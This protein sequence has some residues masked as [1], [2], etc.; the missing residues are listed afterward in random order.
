MF[1]E[2]K[3]ESVAGIKF[4]DADIFPGVVSV[5]APR[6][7]SQIEFDGDYATDP[8]YTFNDQE[9]VFRPSGL[10]VPPGEIVTLEFES[11]A[12]GKGL[13]ARIGI[14]RFDLEAGGWLTFKRFPRISNSFAVNQSAN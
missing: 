8:G 9:T 11:G 6:I 14:H 2:D 1:V 4:E 13:L 10:Y 7:E 3:L 12:V 5:D